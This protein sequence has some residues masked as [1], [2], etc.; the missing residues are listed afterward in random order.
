MVDAVKCL[1]LVLPIFPRTSKKYE[2]VMKDDAPQIKC[3]R[4]IFAVFFV[5]Q[6]S[7]MCR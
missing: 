4:R 1:S 5:K 6:N 7:K 2:V 3:L